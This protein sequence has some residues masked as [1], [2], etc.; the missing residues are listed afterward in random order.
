MTPEER[1]AL[2]NRLTALAPRFNDGAA[3][4]LDQLRRLSLWDLEAAAARDRNDALAQAEL[5]ARAVT[6][7]IAATPREL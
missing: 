5:A 1:T 7:K 2:L 6:L 4:R 3:S